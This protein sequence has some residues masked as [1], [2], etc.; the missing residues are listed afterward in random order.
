MGQNMLA[1]TARRAPAEVQGQRKPLF[2]RLGIGRRNSVGYRRGASVPVIGMC[3]E[4]KNVLMALSA[5]I[6][7]E[8]VM[9]V[10]KH[11]FRVYCRTCKGPNKAETKEMDLV[12]K[13]YIE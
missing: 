5:A 10:R 8:R 11:L 3:S 6:V 7:G 1:C 12:S 13:A 4:V 2:A 9:A